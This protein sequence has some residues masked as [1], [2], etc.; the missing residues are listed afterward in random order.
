MDGEIA[1]DVRTARLIRLRVYA[2]GKAE[3]VGKA[4]DRRRFRLLIA[5]V[6]A[7]DA[8]ARVVPPEAVTVGYASEY[9]APNRPYSRDTPR[10]GWAGLCR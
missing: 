9:R 4:G 5:I 2:D 1:I 8:V 7:T 6:E 3:P 10:I